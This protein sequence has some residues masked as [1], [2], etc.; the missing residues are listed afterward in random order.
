MSLVLKSNSTYTGKHLSANLNLYVA[1]VIADGGQITSRAMVSDAFLFIENN[2]ITATN[3]F[4][5]TSPEFGIKVVSGR[6]IKLYSL[7]GSAGDMVVSGNIGFANL[8]TTLNA[9]EFVASSLNRIQSVGEIAQRT[10]IAIVSAYQCEPN[11]YYRP[12]ASIAGAFSP[13]NLSVMRINRQT[14]GIDSH[15]NGSS[16]KVATSKA[17][18]ALE[19]VGV[20]HTN[21]ELVMVNG[22]SVLGRIAAPS[23]ATTTGAHFLMGKE[24]TVPS[25]SDDYNGKIAETWCMTN[26]SIDKVQLVASRLQGIYLTP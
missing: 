17:A 18:G 14:S 22:T 11:T 8:K 16:Y 15:Y 25:G 2:G 13:S 24:S 26:T 4:S 23:I 1:R 9:L 19:V 10:D 6:V 20:V 12:I 3:C 21:S 5:V 7:F